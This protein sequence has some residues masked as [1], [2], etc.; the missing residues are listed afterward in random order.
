MAIAWHALLEQQHAVILN[1]QKLA[2]GI[3]HRRFAR[4]AAAQFMV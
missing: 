3:W 1:I 2:E 4:A